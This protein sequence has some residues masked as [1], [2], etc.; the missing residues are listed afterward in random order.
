[1]STFTVFDDCYFKSY[2]VA[3]MN[4]ERQATFWQNSARPYVI[5][6]S[7]LLGCPILFFCVLSGFV[8]IM[9][10]YRYCIETE[11]MIVYD[12]R[13]VLNDFVNVMLKRPFVTEISIID[14]EN[15]CLTINNK[16]RERDLPPLLLNQFKEEGIDLFF[17]NDGTISSIYIT[18]TFRDNDE[19]IRYR[20]LFNQK[21]IAFPLSSEDYSKMLSG[22]VLL[23]IDPHLSL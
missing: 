18:S 6:L 3:V 23:N 20:I 12:V 7:I 13:G 17:N 1:M 10:S 9:L 2:G 19:A 5:C 16:T 22:A 11:E 4:R 8:N 14:N 15:A 21:N